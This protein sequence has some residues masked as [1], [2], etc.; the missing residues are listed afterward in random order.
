MQDEA[1][2]NARKKR[3]GIKSNKLRRT[4]TFIVDLRC[5]RCGERAK[6]RHVEMF[7]TPMT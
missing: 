5:C 4:K 1:A 7:E 6:C 3:N 2:R